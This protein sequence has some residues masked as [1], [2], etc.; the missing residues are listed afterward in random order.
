MSNGALWNRDQLDTARAEAKASG[1]VPALEAIQQVD[2]MLRGVDAFKR[3]IEVERSLRCTYAAAIREVQTGLAKPRA[4]VT[5]K[6]L[7]QM[8]EMAQET[9]AGVDGGEG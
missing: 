5:R 3:A 9:L 7:I 2:A 1:N 4:K 6:M 8:I